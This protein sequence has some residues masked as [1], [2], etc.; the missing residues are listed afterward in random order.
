MTYQEFSQRDMELQAQIND[1]RRDSLNAQ[2]QI[3]ANEIEITRL[4]D[5]RT[6]L[7]HEYAKHENPE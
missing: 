7:S 1:Y 3:I 2:Q 6:A 4:Q 5:K